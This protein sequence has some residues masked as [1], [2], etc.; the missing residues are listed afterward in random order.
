MAAWVNCYSDINERPWRACIRFGRMQALTSDHEGTKMAEA[1][2]SVHQAKVHA[3]L[4]AATITL[5]RRAA[6]KAT[7][8][9]LQAQGLRPS[10]IPHCQIVARA[11]QYLAQHRELISEA[12]AVVERWRVEGVFGKRFIR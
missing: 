11:N 8:V 12:K 1:S 2:H 6:I 5:A 10:H 9:E 7:K 3:T 4:G